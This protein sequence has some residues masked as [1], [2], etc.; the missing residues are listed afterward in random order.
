MYSL[1]KGLFY[2]CHSKVAFI[3]CPSVNPGYALVDT[4]TVA[5]S[6]ML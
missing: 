3:G 5:G 2:A 1:P 6:V 4:F